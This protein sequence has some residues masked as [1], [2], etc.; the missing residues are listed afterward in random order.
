[1]ELLRT[2]EQVAGYRLRMKIAAAVLGLLLGVVLHS[3][4]AVAEGASRPGVTPDS[5]CVTKSEHAAI[6]EHRTTREEAER[7][8]D[9]EGASISQRAGVNTWK[10][11]KYRGCDSG[12][13]ASGARRSTEVFI[14]YG[15]TGIVTHAGRITVTIHRG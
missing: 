14:W 15:R 4:P 13:T 8:L 3:T 12:K 7:I 1:M 11:R 10:I 2:V 9:W 5:R 6:K